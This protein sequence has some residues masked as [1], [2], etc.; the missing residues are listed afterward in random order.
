MACYTQ[1]LQK[2]KKQE[3]MPLPSL[4][5][6]S[7]KKNVEFRAGMGLKLGNGISTWH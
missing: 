1:P 2:V 3:E 7:L 6:V 4:S 5:P